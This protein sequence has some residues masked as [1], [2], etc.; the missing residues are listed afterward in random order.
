MLSY[1]INNTN[2]LGGSAP[3]IQASLI[4]L[5]RVQLAAT[6]RPETTCG[7]VPPSPDTDTH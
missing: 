2:R 4:F 3:Q 5:E 6:F 1:A 7:I